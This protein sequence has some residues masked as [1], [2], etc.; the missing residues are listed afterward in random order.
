MQ[1]LFDKYLL[2]LRSLKDHKSVHLRG[3]EGSLARKENRQEDGSQVAY[4]S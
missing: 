3:D 2:K 4:L 1:I